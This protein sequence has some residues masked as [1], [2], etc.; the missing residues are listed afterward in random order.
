LIGG[1]NASRGTWLLLALACAGSTGCTAMLDGMGLTMPQQLVHGGVSAP[2]EILELWDTGWTLND[3]P[4]IGMRVLVQPADR[5]AYEAT[6]EKTPISRL[7]VPQFQPGN[8]I[9]VRFDP[10][11]PAIVAVDSGGSVES[12]SLPSTGNPYRDRFESAAIEGPVFLP[13]PAVPELYLGTGDISRDM[14]V[15]FENDFS[16]LGSSSVRGAS[17][18]QQ[19][20][21]HGEEIGAALVV[22]YGFLEPPPGMELD[23]L[24][25]ARR[26]GGS[27]SVAMPGG[28]SAS[29]LVSG[30]LGPEDQF[31]TYWGKTRPAILG[32]VSRSLDAQE[33]ERLDRRDG[34]VV[35]SV[36]NGSPAAEAQI[37]AGDVLVA[38]ADQPFTEP[39]ASAELIRSFAGR[40]VKIDLLRDGNPMSVVA[41]LNPAAP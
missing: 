25:Y 20:V 16:L 23:V 30:S 10:N 2:A 9:P 14:S 18:P 33:Q 24:P 28:G 40:V 5:P 38:I 22:V 19:A 12:A 4:V 37:V 31:A 1:R 35:Q 15:L 17:D 36:A 6:I 13:A 7:A 34:I 39:R 26:I 27:G 11:D 41:Q 8:V 3:N 21:E 32:I 29:K